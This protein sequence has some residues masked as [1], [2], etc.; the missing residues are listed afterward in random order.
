MYLVAKHPIHKCP[1][2]GD[3]ECW[4]ARTIHSFSYLRKF[5][6]EERK[7]TNYRRFFRSSTIALYTGTAE[8]YCVVTLSAPLY[9]CKVSRNYFSLSTLHIY[10]T[11]NF[12]KIQI[13]FSLSHSVFSHLRNLQ[14]GRFGVETQESNSL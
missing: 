7:T 1:L 10:Y 4:L 11:L 5:S 9:A 8:F 3:F 2:R 13:L 12:F 14:A 6:L